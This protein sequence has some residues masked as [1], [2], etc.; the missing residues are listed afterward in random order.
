MTPLQKIKNGI[1]TNNMPKVAAGY[2]EMTGENIK[3]ESNEYEKF[4]YSIKDL[5]VKYSNE[6]Q[7]DEVIVAEDTDSTKEVH[8]NKTQVKSGKKLVFKPQKEMEFITDDTPPTE[9]EIRL[10]EE[11]VKN[12]AKLPKRKSCQKKCDE[13]GNIVDSVYTSIGEDGNINLCI[14]CESKRVKKIKK[15]E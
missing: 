11:V 6:S 13:C 3:I 10:N 7:V 9:E 1:E 14:T 15:G 8:Q 4:Y 2:K 12:K 5:V